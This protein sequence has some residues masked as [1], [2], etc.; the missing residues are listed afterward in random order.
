[1]L[2]QRSFIRRGLHTIEDD[3]I[4]VLVIRR[5]IH[6]L[7]SL[8]RMCQMKLFMAKSKIIFLYYRRLIMQYQKVDT[9]FSFALENV[10]DEIVHGEI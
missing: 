10:S 1:V 3:E 7:A 5:L 8:W 6:H 2:R 4:G 9:S